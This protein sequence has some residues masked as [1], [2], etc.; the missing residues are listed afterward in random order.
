MTFESADS[1]VEWLK[2]GGIDLSLWGKQGNKTA[3]DL[4]LELQQGDC[5]LQGPPPVRL[6]RV[7]QVVI[8][9]E[10]KVL[11]EGAQEMKDGRIRRRNF[12]PSEKMKPGES[13]PAAALR[14]LYEELGIAPNQVIIL[15]ECGAQ[16]E[17]CES[18]SYPGLKTCYY[19]FEVAARIRGLPTADFWHDNVAHA[20]HDPVKRHHWVWIA[21]SD[22]PVGS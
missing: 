1:L 3:V 9:Q 18:P 2:E 7:V 21:G 5:I 22:R 10:G 19:L 20:L 15:S 13:P 16:V 8:Q 14:C 17:E 4:W 6:V 11:I 12:Y